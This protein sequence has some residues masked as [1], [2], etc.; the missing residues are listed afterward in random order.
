MDTVTRVS[1]ID[2]LKN[3]VRAFRCQPVQTL[4]LGVNVIKCDECEYKSGASLRE[5]LL[6]TGG[7]RAA[8]MAYC[9]Y[10]DLPFG[11]EGEAD[12]SRY[13]SKLVDAYLEYREFDKDL[14]FDEYIE[15]ALRRKYKKDSKGT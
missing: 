9:G 3:A 4:H 8:F 11:V 15:N 13:V 12:I 10:I 6:V 2:R 5:D 1:F 7:A 14:N